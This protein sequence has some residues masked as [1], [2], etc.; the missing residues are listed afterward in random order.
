MDKSDSWEK[1]N[2]QRGTPAFLEELIP[3]HPGLKT[4]KLGKRLHRWTA[5]KT[6]RSSWGKIRQSM[7][8][9]N[10]YLKLKTKES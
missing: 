5:W 6:S 2:R 7:I 10:L 8:F 3:A 4:R 1:E 9:I